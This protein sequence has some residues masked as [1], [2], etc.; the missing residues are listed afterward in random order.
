VGWSAVWALKRNGAITAPCATP[1]SILEIFER[2][3]PEQMEKWRSLR[4]DLISKY[5]LII[6]LNFIY[7]I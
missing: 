5:R 1:T 3:V 6:N 2:V 7:F 4:Y